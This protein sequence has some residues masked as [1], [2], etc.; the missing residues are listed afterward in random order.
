MATTQLFHLPGCTTF[1]VLSVIQFFIKV[2]PETTYNFL[3]LSLNQSAI[4]CNTNISSNIA[5]DQRKC[6]PDNIVSCILFST[7]SDFGRVV[8]D[9][10]RT[11]LT[12]RA[13]A[14]DFGSLFN[15]VRI[16]SISRNCYT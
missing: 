12:R 3:L 16:N 6:S 9:F 1:F 2:K 7:S 11:Q 8:V 10:G 14:M 4:R 5:D 13:V 15:I